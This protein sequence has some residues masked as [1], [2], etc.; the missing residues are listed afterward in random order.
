MWKS[1]RG[2]NV[3]SGNKHVTVANCN[4]SSTSRVA[5]VKCQQNALIIRISRVWSLIETHQLACRCTESSFAI[6]LL[7]PAKRATNKCAAFFYFG[8]LMRSPWG[9]K[10]ILRNCF[11]LLCLLIKKCKHKSRS[12]SAITSDNSVQDY[13]SL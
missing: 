9:G 10:N 12:N 5:G 11:A 1:G 3:V 4:L 13:Q 7:Q 8:I 2:D 6:R